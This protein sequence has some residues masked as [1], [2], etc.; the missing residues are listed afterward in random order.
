MT[1]TTNTKLDERAGRIKQLKEQLAAA[2]ERER[3]LQKLV[4]Y[5]AHKGSC[6]R[7]YNDNELCDCGFAQALK[8]KQT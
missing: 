1:E 7:R 2:Q 4:E 5:A 8:E 6:V 3:R